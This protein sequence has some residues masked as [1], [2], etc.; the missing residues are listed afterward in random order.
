MPIKM[1][2]PGD[3]VWT[4]SGVTHVKVVV[5]MGHSSARS[6][7]M[8]HVKGA[9][10]TPYHPYLN[11]KDEWTTGA[12]TVPVFEWTEPGLKLYNL[13]LESGHI[14]DAGNVLACTLAHGFKG[15]V[16]EHPFFGTNS[17]IEC[18]K[19]AKGWEYGKPY[20]NDL[21]VHRRDGLIVDWYE[22][23]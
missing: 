3:L 10:I 9:C 18:L 20:Y 16:I 2:M 14:I 19:M 6:L 12:D 8:C 1:L 15:P 13:V 4:P 22:G 11:E 17:V 5:T 23:M 21:Q 7:M